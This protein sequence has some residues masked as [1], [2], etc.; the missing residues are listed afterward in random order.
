[1]KFDLFSSLGHGTRLRFHVCFVQVCL[2]WVHAKRV[3]VR[4]QKTQTLHK[5]VPK[6][7]DMSIEHLRSQVHRVALVH[8]AR[9]HVLALSS[10]ALENITACEAP[11]HEQQ[12]E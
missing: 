6:T 8:V 12:Q 4:V 9:F 5:L 7:T 3:H 11:G 1:M 10:Y 2:Q